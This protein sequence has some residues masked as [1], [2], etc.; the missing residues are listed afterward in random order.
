M[1]KI[2]ERSGFTLVEIMIVVAII[3][4]LVAIGMPSFLRARKNARVARVAKNIKVFADAFQMYC[5][6]EGK[7]PLDTHLI[8]PA[9]MQ[10]N[11]TEKSWNSDALGG[12]YNWEGP[13]WGEGGGYDYAGIALFETKATTDE[14]E[15]LDSLLDD[16]DLSTGTFRLTDNGRYTY[17][18]EE[19]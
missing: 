10:G 7:Y 2:Y 15:A 17:I 5:M 19:R 18:I 14:L 11:I 8:Y 12:S 13:S 9:S 16:G 1:K 4:L 6:E 3:G